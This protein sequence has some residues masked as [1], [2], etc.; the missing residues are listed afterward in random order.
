MFIHKL[1]YLKYIIQFTADV[2]EGFVF[3]AAEFSAAFTEDWIADDTEFKFCIAFH[4][5]TNVPNCSPCP[6][7]EHR[8]M[9][10][11]EHLGYFSSHWL[12]TY[13]LA[14]SP[15]NITGT[16][17]SI[18]INIYIEINT[19][20]LLNIILIVGFSILLRVYSQS[21]IKPPYAT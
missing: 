3:G 1:M 14:E 10:V 6:V 16:E 11:E 21:Q 13:L 17:T 9:F 20:V 4:R 12:H 18:Y 5:H 2:N 15:L 8:Q 19:Y 7:A